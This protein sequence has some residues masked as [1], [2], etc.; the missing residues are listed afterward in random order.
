[1][2]NQLSIIL[3]AATGSLFF[4]GCDPAAGDADQGRRPPTQVVAVPATQQAVAETISLVGSLLANEMVEIKSEVDGQIEQI[5]FKEGQEVTNG[6]QLIQ[7]DDDKLVKE[8]AESEAT[9]QLRQAS[10]ERD[11]ELY[12]A[13][14][15]SG[16]E[17]DQTFSLYQVS[18][19]V[20]DLR[21]RRVRD[22]RINAPFDGVVGARNVSP[23]QVI[24]R[25]TPLTWVVDLD[26]VKVEVNVPER[27]LGQ[28]ALG[29][30]ISMQIDAYPNE[31]FTGQVFFISPYV[32][33]DLRTA[34]IKAEIPNPKQRLKPGMFANLELTLKIRAQ[35][36]VIPESALARLFEGDQASVFVVSNET[37]QMRRVTLGIRLPGK[38]EILK[39]IRPGDEVIVEGAQKIGPGAPVSLA[40][41]EA[42]APY[43]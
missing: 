30:Q 1:M 20:L 21:K 27:F 3:L 2:R 22:T 9:F 28:L 12:E 18:E 16:Q 25:N 24:A 19:A 39:G 7:L 33:P 5:L 26:P 23:G 41:A 35:A 15:I 42:T 38:V 34:L 17:Y 4:T 11:K 40:P 36:V 31:E 14:L 32:D 10:F 43:R 29:Q 37:A 8:V 13:K 6:Q